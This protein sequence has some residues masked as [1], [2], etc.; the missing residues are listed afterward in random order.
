MAKGSAFDH[1]AAIGDFQAQL[2]ACTVR[3]TCGRSFV[4][5]AKLTV[6]LKVRV[7]PGSNITQASRLLL[8][9]Y[10]E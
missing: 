2:R 6:W 9:A 10:A 7:R 8:A 5:T 3:A 1:S 4:R